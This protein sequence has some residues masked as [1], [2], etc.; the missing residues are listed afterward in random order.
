M[1]QK[2]KAKDDLYNRK[3]YQQW[4]CHDVSLTVF[5]FFYFLNEDEYIIQLHAR[6]VR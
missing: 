1:D 4:N 6:C 2:C 5:F 3:N